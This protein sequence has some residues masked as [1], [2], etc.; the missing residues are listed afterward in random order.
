M[1]LEIINQSGKRSPISPQECVVIEDARHGV[2]AAH[3]AGMKCVA[4]STSH[5]AFELSA[6]DLVVP[7]ISSLKLSQLEDLFLAGGPPGIATKPQTQEQR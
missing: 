1:A 3:L 5:P 6:A 2:A 4:I 7:E